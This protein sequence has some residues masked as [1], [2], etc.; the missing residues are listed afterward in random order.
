MK[1]RKNARSA[2][3]RREGKARGVLAGQANRAE[4]A[5]SF[6]AAAKAAPKR[7]GRR[8]D[9]GPA[10]CADRPSRPHSPRS[11]APRHAAGRTVSLRRCR[12][13]G[14]RIA[15]ATGVPPA[16]ADRA[17]KRAGLSRI[18]VTFPP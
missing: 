10:G 18:R 17:L 1:R 8:R 4:A 2:P 16:T 6:G 5:A 11:P 3:L 12:L 9:I 7:A 14:V 15:A 13:T